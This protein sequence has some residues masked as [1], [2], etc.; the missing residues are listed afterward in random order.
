MSSYSIGQMN[1]LGDGLEETGFTADDLTRIGQNSKL[2]RQILGITR[3]QFS[4]QRPEFPTWVHVQLG[5]YE[6]VDALFADLEKQGVKVLRCVRDIAAKI[7]LSGEGHLDLIKTP[8]SDLG[9]S[10]PA[11]FDKVIA[12]AREFGLELVPQDVP[13]H[14]GLQAGEQV[15]RGELVIFA[16][17]S[18][19]DSDGDPDVFSL[20]RG[21]N[22]TLLLDAIL[23]YPDG[24]LLSE[25]RLVFC[26]T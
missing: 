1:Q 16:M 6:S 5:G 19:T 3:G 7:E 8:V 2:R 18:V 26:R 25:H 9:F 17:E 22:G 13:L 15:E 24:L 20:S 12:R 4:I 10:E 14:V 23:G 21:P 11:R